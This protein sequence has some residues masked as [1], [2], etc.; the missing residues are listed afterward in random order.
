MKEGRTQTG[1]IWLKGDSTTGILLFH[2]WTAP[3]DEM[4]PLAKKLQAKGYTVYA[5]I[6]RG[7]STRPEDLE[8]VTWQDWLA[9]AKIALEKLRKD[10]QNIFVGGISMG[11]NISLLLSEEKN[12]SGIILLGAPIRFRFQEMAEAALYIMGLTKKYRKK[13]YPRFRRNSNYYCL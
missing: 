1:P 13:Y 12:V 7:H 10:A 2:G 11:G 6:L 3:P 5:P 8:G 4:L 9:D